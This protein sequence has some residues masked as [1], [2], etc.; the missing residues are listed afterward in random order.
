MGWVL[1]WPNY[2]RRSGDLF[3]CLFICLFRS[4]ECV[5]VPPADVVLLEGILVLYDNHIRDLLHMKLFVDTDSDTR[6]ARRGEPHPLTVGG[7]N[8]I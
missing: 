4:K 2:A 6:L 7:V 8:L 5:T 1:G 3:V